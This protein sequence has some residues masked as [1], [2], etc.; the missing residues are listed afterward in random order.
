MHK[1]SRFSSTISTIHELEPDAVVIEDGFTIN[2]RDVPNAAE[3]VTDWIS[4]LKFEKDR[5]NGKDE[6]I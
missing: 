5:I 1:G 2:E 6:V 3:D 4:G